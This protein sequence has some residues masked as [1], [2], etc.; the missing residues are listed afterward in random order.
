M[1]ISAAG[2]RIQA[3]YKASKRLQIVAICVIPAVSVQIHE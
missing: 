1:L 3:F 2:V